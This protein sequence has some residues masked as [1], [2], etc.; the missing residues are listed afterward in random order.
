[1]RGAGAEQRDE[2]GEG[3]GPHGGADGAQ[4]GEV[5][6]QSGAGGGHGGCA[7]DGGVPVGS[8]VTD[9]QAAGWPEVTGCGDHVSSVASRIPSHQGVCLY[10]D[11]N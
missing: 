8:E 10:G 9:A 4:T 1:M 7:H 6:R 11:I 5:E 2:Q 3:Q